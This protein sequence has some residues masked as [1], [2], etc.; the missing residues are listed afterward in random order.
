MIYWMLI[1]LQFKIVTRYK[2]LSSSTVKRVVLAA[3]R[4]LF[5]FYFK[6]N[7]NQTNRIVNFHL[8]GKCRLL[9]KKTQLAYL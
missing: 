1:S 2:F 6:R 7:S 5:D 9:H 4:F 8:V 3:A